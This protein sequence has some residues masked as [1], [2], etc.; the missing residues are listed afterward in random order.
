MLGE[1]RW[2]RIVLFGSGALVLSI[3]VMFLTV[4]GYAAFLGF[5]AMGP[6]DQDK[7]SE[8]ARWIGP[9]M[10]PVVGFV[11][12]ALAAWLGG[13]VES[14]RFEHGLAIGIVAGLLGLTLNLLGGF[15]MRDLFSLMLDLVA[16]S[17]G[18]WLANLGRARAAES[19]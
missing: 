16:G 14:R 10:G 2:I 5:Q 17:L 8:F 11:L 7:I 12:V 19:S 3:A 4:F 13:R 9:R 18:G 6:P 1:L 15:E